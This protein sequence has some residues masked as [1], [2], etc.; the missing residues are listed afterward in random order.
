[1]Q[2]YA[3]THAVFLPLHAEVLRNLTS[4]HPA[5]ALLL[6]ASKFDLGLESLAARILLN[7][8]TPLDI[9]FGFGAVSCTNFLGHQFAQL[10]MSH[11]FPADIQSRGL[12]HLPIYKY[13]TH[14]RLHFDALSAWSERT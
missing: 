5:S 13:G 11:D 14:S 1:M 6:R 10:P 3:D 12:E 2:H 4:K 7:M 8:S 9:T